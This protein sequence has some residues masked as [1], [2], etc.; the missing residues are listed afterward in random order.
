[1]S[2]EIDG[3]IVYEDLCHKCRSSSHSKYTY[4]VDHEYMHQSVGI[5]GEFHSLFEKK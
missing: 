4:D 2:K 1:M 5:Y 3:E